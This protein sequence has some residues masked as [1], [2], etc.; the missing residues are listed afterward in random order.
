[1]VKERN[2]SALPCFSVWFVIPLGTLI[3]FAAIIWS[4][5]I[6]I[7]PATTACP[8][9]VL[10]AF[11][12]MTQPERAGRITGNRSAV[13]EFEPFLT[14]EQAAE[15]L[16]IHHETLQKLARRGEIRGTHIGELSRFRVSDLN[17]WCERNQRA[18]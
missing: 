7:D 12:R 18:S 4:N 2:A 3:V 9:C 8:W 1:M 13:P 15:L 10:I 14:S 17:A 11:Q 5:H 6:G 16:Q